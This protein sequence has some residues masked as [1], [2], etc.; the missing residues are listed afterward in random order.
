MYA[1]SVSTNKTSQQFGEHLTSPL[2]RE[3]SASFTENRIEFSSHLPEASL[4]NADFE[5]RWQSC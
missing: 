4:R 2:A 3:A 1:R 5:Q